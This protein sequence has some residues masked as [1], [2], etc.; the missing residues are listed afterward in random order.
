MEYTLEDMKYAF[1]AAREFNSSDGTVDIQ[2]VLSYKGADNSDL[3]PVYPNFE[4]YMEALK[5]S[6]KL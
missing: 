3:S 4:D 5:L 6:N 2:I 1:E